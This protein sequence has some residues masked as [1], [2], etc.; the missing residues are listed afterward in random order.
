MTAWP[1]LK[2][3]LLQPVSDVFDNRIK[4]ALA[5]NG[6]V[7][8]GQLYLVDTWSFEHDLIEFSRKSAKQVRSVL[9]SF[10]LID[11]LQPYNKRGVIPQ[12]GLSDAN[13][14]P[15]VSSARQDEKLAD[16]YLKSAAGYIRPTQSLMD[17][18]F[19]SG[20]FQYER[21]KFELFIEKHKEY[22]TLAAHRNQPIKSHVILIKDTEARPFQ[23][24]KMAWLKKIMPAAF[25]QG[26]KDD[27]INA[28][29][30]D[31]ANDTGVATAFEKAYGFLEG[32]M[33]LEVLKALEPSRLS[34]ETQGEGV[35]NVV[36]IGSTIIAEFMPDN[37]LSVL[38]NTYR[39]TVLNSLGDNN[40]LVEA[41][42]SIHQAVQ[43]IVPAILMQR[44]D[45]P[46]N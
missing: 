9:R 44:L 3:L 13:K 33:T 6:I 45:L 41:V 23:S 14:V 29:L 24:L 28:V 34:S 10:D 21:E 17:A 7:F 22:F 36:S 25:H 26:L 12:N 16:G 31:V 39:A 46:K 11:Q 1:D 2:K 19:Q 43:V 8:L 15:Q 4:N 38:S 42:Q 20:N 37:T 30:A 40:D 18:Y 32:A 5:R 35:A 27:F